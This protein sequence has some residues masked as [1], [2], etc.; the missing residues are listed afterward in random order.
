MSIIKKSKG[1]KAFDIVNTT[2]LIGLSLV[3]IIPFLVVLGTSFL[4]ESELIQRGSY[5]LIPQNPVLTS[6]EVLLGSG[7]F[8]YGAYMITILRVVIGTGLNLIFTGML[9]YGLSR[10]NLPGRNFFIFLVFITMLFSGGLVPSYIL[11]K[12]LNLIDNFWVMIFPTLINAWWMI[13]MR[14]FFSQ[15]PESLHESAVIDGATPLRIFI[16]VIIPLSAPAFAT[17]GIFYA[18]YHW[19]SWFDAS[20]FINKENL[21][22]IQ[23]LI[24]RIVL[25][26]SDQD[27]NNEILSTMT[28]RPPSM[29]LKAAAI[30][31][32]TVPILCVYPFLQKYFVK[33][34]MVGSI[35][36]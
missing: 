6:Y 4:S 5:V 7:S 10:K 11:Y 19:N 33:G 20:V 29:A 12:G 15:I 34:M 22:P 32:S 18:V 21:Q 9:A 31:V 16:S 8:I 14:N 26:M 17:I 27:V 13:I 3:F 25:T 35:K 1:E 30:I 2:I 36:G 24:R 23:V 28:Q